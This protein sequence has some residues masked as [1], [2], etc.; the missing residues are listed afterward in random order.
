[1]QT[2][3]LRDLGNG[4]ILRCATAK[5]TAAL[6]DFNA[7]IH[8]DFG[9]D[10][11]D[12][13]VRAWT[14]DLIEKPHPLFKPE[15][16][17]IVEDIKSGKIV[18]SMNL[19]SQTWAYGGIRFG[20]GRPELVGTD[21]AYRNRGLVRAQFELVHS[22]SQARGE[23]LQAITGIPYYYRL[24]GYEM[25]VDLGGGRIGLTRS[26][27]KLKENETEPFRIR[28]AGET[29]LVFISNL[30]EQV[31][32][33]YLLNCIRDE[34]LWRYELSGKS[35]DNVNR[36]VLCLIETL[37]GEPV[38]YLAHPVNNWGPTLVATQYEIRAG[39]PWSQITPS[40]IRYLYQTGLANAARAEKQSEHE[41]FGFWLGREHPVYAVLHDSLPRIR[42]PYSWYIRVPDLPGFIRLVSAVLEQ[43]LAASPYQGYTG[44]LKITF[45]RQGLFLG[46][47]DGRLVKVESYTPTPVG[48][49]GD[50]AFPD[51]TFLHLL[52]GYRSLDELLFAFADCW[53]ENDDVYGLLNALFPKQVC[54]IWPVS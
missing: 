30:Y 44:S 7:H 27:P 21:P 33:R 49:T 12:E 24:F 13:G 5:D 47:E 51:L 50:A 54:N 48:H 3:T 38:G 29:D 8:S 22:W 41:G 23:A 2:K 26:V 4:L 32:P 10:Q 35:E 6:A 53:Y 39:I 15:D 19:I 40:V 37:A 25:T 14:R 28:P 31:H 45:Y 1:M 46:I 17:T 16:F 43:N 52:F 18:S 42:K 36:S 34:A 11:P 9:P 20:V